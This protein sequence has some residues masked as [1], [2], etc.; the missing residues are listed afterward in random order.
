MKNYTYQPSKVEKEE[1]IHMPGWTLDQVRKG[2]MGPLSNSHGVK[3]YNSSLELL[4]VY[5]RVTMFF[6]Y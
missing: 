4:Q 2:L 5:S 3:G 1:E 6:L